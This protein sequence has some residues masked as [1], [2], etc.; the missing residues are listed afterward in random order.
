LKPISNSDLI[1]KKMIRRFLPAFLLALIFGSFSLLAQTGGVNAPEQLDKPY[2]ILISLDGFRFDYVDVYQ[3]PRLSEVIEQGVAAHSMI[4]CFPTKTFPNHYSIAT[5][6]RPESHGLVDNSFFWP[7]REKEYKISD[8]EV[9]E[10][11]SWYGGT[12]LWVNAEQQGMVSASYFFV[13]SEAD[14]QGIHPTYFKKYDGSIANRKRIDQM[15]NWLK[16]PAEKRPHLITGYFSDMDDRG[17]RV[18]PGDST[19]IQEA[20]FQLDADLGYLVDELAQ[21]DLPVNVILVSDH[22]MAD[23]SIDHFLPYEQLEDERYRIV[24]DGAVV[25]V[26]LKDTSDRQGAWDHLRSLEG[27]FKVYTQE[28]FPFYG[29][30]KSDERLGDFLVL[31]H[32]P[33][34]FTSARSLGFMKGRGV[35][36]TGQHGFAPQYQEMHAIFYA[37]G[38]DIKEGARVP[39]FENIHVYPFVCELLGL[40]I[41]D[42]VE[43][44]RSVL[45]P[46]IEKGP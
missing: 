43:G 7:S 40:A 29:A 17:H 26:Y 24:N 23:V 27:P 19:K 39:S 33:Y 25:H 37:W 22:G 13:G 16:L 41:P 10:D 35:K 36:M 12:P 45:A 8:R 18:G 1:A 20:L 46:I 11:G 34:Y 21:L 31:P 14:V 28:N 32:F 9:V 44:S 2:V 3:P 15:I 30:T 4:P 5:G 42:E 6:M 38:P